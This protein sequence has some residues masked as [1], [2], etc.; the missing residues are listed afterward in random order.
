[1]MVIDLLLMEVLRYKRNRFLLKISTNLVEYVLI[2]SHLSSGKGG[3]YF[4]I[5]LS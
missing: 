5:W 1:M 2:V 4:W 3:L